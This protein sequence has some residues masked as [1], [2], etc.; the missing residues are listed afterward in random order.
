MLNIIGFVGL[1]LGPRPL[2]WTTFSITWVAC[3][4][5]L[6]IPV[7]EDQ[8]SHPLQLQDKTS[9]DTML[10]KSL[11][12]MLTDRLLDMENI[13][14]SGPECNPEPEVSGL[15]RTDVLTQLVP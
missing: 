13:I 14:L 15:K 2:I 4:P 7:E 12:G 9:M 5:D 8:L 10:Q 1:H 11:V 6:A 3:V